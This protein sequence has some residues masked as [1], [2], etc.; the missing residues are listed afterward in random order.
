[1]RRL[2]YVSSHLYHLTFRNDADFRGESI[3]KI[4]KIHPKTY[5]W[6]GG[7]DVE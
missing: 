5:I 1:M 2:G 7:K 3:A 6:K 4:L